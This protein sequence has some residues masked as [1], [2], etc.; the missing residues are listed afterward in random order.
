MVFFYSYAQSI[1]YYSDIGP[2]RFL[3]K[4]PETRRKSDA[5][6]LLFFEIRKLLYA[7]FEK[8]VYLP[9][10]AIDKIHY[11]LLCSFDKNNIC[12]ICP[13]IPN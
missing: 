5:K 11:G 3:P 10:P 2:C 1:H 8:N 4:S 13:K 7:F 12:H 6:V 9:Y